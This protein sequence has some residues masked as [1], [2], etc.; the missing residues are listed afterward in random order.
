MSKVDRFLSRAEEQEIVDAIL[1]AE[2]NTSGEIRVHIE[3]KASIDAF[4]RAQQLFH[5][6]KMD[7]TQN[8]NGVLI[9][10]AVEDRRFVIY[11]DEGIDRVVPSDF[12]EST[13]DAMQEHFREGRFKEGIIA[14]VLKAGQEL[15]KHFPWHHG[16]KDELSNEVSRG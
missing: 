4:S 14:G 10:V 12:W 5:Y 11:G 13:K 1:M 6:L 15:Q 2:R 9:Y 3:A 8:R 7:N 16:D